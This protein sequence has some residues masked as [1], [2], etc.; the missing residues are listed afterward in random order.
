MRQQVRIMPIASAS[1]NDVKST[2]RSAAAQP[3]AWDHH[4]VEAGPAAQTLARRR[5]DGCAKHIPPKAI[6]RVGQP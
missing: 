1:P 4:P 6:H 3:A 2:D 5:W